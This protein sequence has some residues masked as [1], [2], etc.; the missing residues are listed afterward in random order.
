MSA[1]SALQDK[2]HLENKDKSVAWLLQN[3][4]DVQ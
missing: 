4:G 1:Y 3:L 2:I